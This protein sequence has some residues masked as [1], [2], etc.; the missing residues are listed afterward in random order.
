MSVSSTGPSTTGAKSTSVVETSQVQQAEQVAAEVV[1]A[2]EPTETDAAQTMAEDKNTG[3]ASSM[4]ESANHH[5]LSHL[6][7]GMHRGRHLSRHFQRGRGRSA[8]LDY[9]SE[10]NTNAVTR[11][12]NLYNSQYVGSV[13]VGT[14]SQPKKCYNLAATK[15]G[16]ART[17]KMGLKGSMA[18]SALE[19]GESAGAESENS[20]KVAPLAFV[21]R[22]F[23]ADLR[24]KGICHFEEESTINV[25]FDTGSTNLWISSDLCKAEPCTSAVSAVFVA[26]VL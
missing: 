12:E 17:R 19:L 16:D 24:A 7:K 21:A 15:T 8:A 10:K 25:V 14:V 20:R 5:L 3:G 18:M 9:V 2:E 11:L 1:D 22:D 23:A 6:D 13:G 4:Q 26:K